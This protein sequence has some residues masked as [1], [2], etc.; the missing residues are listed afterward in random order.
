MSKFKRNKF[1]LA[2]KERAV[3]LYLN[4]GYSY[5]SIA[6][7]LSTSDTLISLWVEN[8]ERYGIDGLSPRNKI[9]YSVEYKLNLL[10]KI[11]KEKLSLP[12]VSVE[13]H[14]SPSVL[15][16]WQIRYSKYGVEG[17]KRKRGRPSKK[18]EKIISN[19]SNSDYEQLLERNKYLEVE[20]AYLKKLDALI[21]N[22]QK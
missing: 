5:N 21:Q 15:Y 8:Y 3:K 4:D 17:L 22:K 19:N 16:D 18:K 9:H 13:Y 20:V 6:K 10:Q 12:Q 1:S 2:D 14:I 11:E 7:K